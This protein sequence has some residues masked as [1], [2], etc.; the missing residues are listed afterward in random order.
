LAVLEDPLLGPPLFSL[1]LCH[2]DSSVNL[3]H[4]LLIQKHQNCFKA[5]GNFMSHKL[6]R[7]VGSEYLTSLVFEWLILEKPGHLKTGTFDNWN[8]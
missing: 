4:G 7:A 8:I 5:Q 2:Y 1:P 6:L 3:A